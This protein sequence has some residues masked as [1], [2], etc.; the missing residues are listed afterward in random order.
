MQCQYDEGKLIAD[1][2]LVAEDNMP[3]ETLEQL[4]GWAPMTKNSGAN[5]PSS[6]TGIALNDRKCFQLA[7]TDR[8]A[9]S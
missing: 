5:S 4:E 8:G 7:R 6:S 1:S 3:G 2:V 9:L